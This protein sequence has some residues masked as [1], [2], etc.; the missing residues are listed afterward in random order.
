MNDLK[1]FVTHHAAQSAATSILAQ[2]NFQIRGQCSRPSEAS[3]LE[4]SIKKIISTC[5]EAAFEEYH[6]LGLDRLASPT[7][8]S[9]TRK[10][11]LTSASTSSMNFADST[12]GLQ[13][14]KIKDEKDD[15][16][17]TQMN[18]ASEEEQKY[19]P[20]VWFDAAPPHLQFT[21]PSNCTSLST[22]ELLPELADQ[23]MSTSTTMVMCTNTS[24]S[25]TLI[26]FSPPPS[27]S[28]MNFSFPG[29][30]SLGNDPCIVES[31]PLSL[32]GPSGQ[33]GLYQHSDLPSFEHPASFISSMGGW[34]ATRK[35]KSQDDSRMLWCDQFL[36]EEPGQV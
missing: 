25:E 7:S 26:D 17:S 36:F 35:E 23:K 19:I 16:N 8:R 2:E 31:N 34:D 24:A 33:Y 1:E 18:M 12:T 11:E 4:K 21:S 30:D 28:P 13:Q 29:H 3:P 5:V 22:H 32:Q 9:S 14:T 15:I 10:S 27:L 6:I 20:T